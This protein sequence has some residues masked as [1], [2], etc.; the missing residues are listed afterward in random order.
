ML[1]QEDTGEQMH[2]G[3]MTWKK[4]IDFNNTA[5]KSAHGKLTY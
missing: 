3:P 1:G 2:L 5:G 4:N